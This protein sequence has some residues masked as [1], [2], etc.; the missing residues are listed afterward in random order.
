MKERYNL[1]ED[2]LGSESKYWE[3][4]MEFKNEV[5][6][7]HYLQASDGF[8]AMDTDMKLR[9]YKTQRILYIE[10]KAYLTNPTYG[11]ME[12]IKLEYSMLK[13]N[14]HFAGYYLLQHENTG[15]FTGYNWLSV[16]S[17]SGWKPIVK[18]DG[19]KYLS[20]N[21]VMMYL[22]HVLCQTVDII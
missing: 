22:H 16:Y 18:K 15:S 12:T 5:S 17:G 3:P 4:R 10:D 8:V 19:D 21:E 9:N 7:S 13:D 6:Q 2:V 11:Q 1:L 20:G 14:P